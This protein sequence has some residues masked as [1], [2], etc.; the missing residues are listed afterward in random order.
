MNISDNTPS[1]LIMLL[2][3]SVAAAVV[4]GSAATNSIEPPC[5]LS[6]TSSLAPVNFTDLQGTW[7]LSRMTSLPSNLAQITGRLQ[8]I[9][10]VNKKGG[11]RLIFNGFDGHPTFPCR[12]INFKCDVKGG[13]S[14]K[15]LTAPQ[16]YTVLAVTDSIAA[17]YSENALTDLPHPA[18]MILARDLAAVD[19]TPIQPV[20]E[21]FC[22]CHSTYPSSRFYATKFA[23]FSCP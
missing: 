21:Q 17:I 23:S 14:C 6:D 7:Y 16:T 9:K 12:P 15:G 11:Q 1:A 20:L 22:G 19:F 13:N 4:V 18:L 8:K 3:A 10:L 2:L 5:D